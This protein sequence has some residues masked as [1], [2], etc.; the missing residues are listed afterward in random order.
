MSFAERCLFDAPDNEQLC[1][2]VAEP[3]VT[4]VMPKMWNTLRSS[5]QQL[6]SHG[7]PSSCSTS[8]TPSGLSSL[9]CL[10]PRDGHGHIS[11]GEQYGQYRGKNPREGWLSNG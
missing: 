6:Q 9:Y 11:A 5:P 2:D 3:H 7:A 1:T 8:S 4:V 10:E